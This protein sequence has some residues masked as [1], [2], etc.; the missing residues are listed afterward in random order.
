M[1]VPLKT[2]DSPKKS[3]IF[4]TIKICCVLKNLVLWARILYI[5]A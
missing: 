1:L 5:P 2:T 4:L 3:S